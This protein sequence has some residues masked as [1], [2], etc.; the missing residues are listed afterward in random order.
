MA[1]RQAARVV[2]FEADELPVAPRPKRPKLATYESLICH[3]DV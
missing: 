1:M 3:V 2:D